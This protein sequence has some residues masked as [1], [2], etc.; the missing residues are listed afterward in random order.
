M[1]K[2]VQQVARHLEGEANGMRIPQT[3]LRIIIIK[4]ISITGTDDKLVGKIVEQSRFRQRVFKRLADL[5][6]MHIVD[7]QQLEHMA[8]LHITPLL[9]D[10]IPSSRDDGSFELRTCLYAVTHLQFGR[11]TNL[12]TEILMQE[13]KQETGEQDRRLRTELPKVVSFRLVAG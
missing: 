6:Q 7:V 5:R 2:P 8:R 9:P 3:I 10:I 13:G 1:G 4:R 12:T 11:C